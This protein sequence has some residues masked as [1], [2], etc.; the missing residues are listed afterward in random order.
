VLDQRDAAKI[1]ECLIAAHARACAPCKN[2]ARDLARILHVCP[3]ILR[4]HVSLAQRAGG[5]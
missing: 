2:K 1:E 5:R 4:L 3:A